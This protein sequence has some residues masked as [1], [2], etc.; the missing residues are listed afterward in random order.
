ME[1][2]TALG[3]PNAIRYV[4]RAAELCDA[5][6]TPVPGL[7]QECVDYI[8]AHP[9]NVYDMAA[10]HLFA[11]G[12][13]AAGQRDKAAAVYFTLLEASLFDPISMPKARLMS[14]KVQVRVPKPLEQSP[15]M[16]QCNSDYPLS[17]STE[18]WIP[19]AQTLEPLRCGLCLC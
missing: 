1:K 11:K 6:S 9:S 19:L 17:K 13:K 12:L 14:C 18:S 4:R 16:R 15:A 5:L 7:S 10:L 2:A 8:K 3:T